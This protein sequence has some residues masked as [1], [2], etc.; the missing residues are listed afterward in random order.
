MHSFFADL[1]LAFYMIAGTDLQAPEI[2]KEMFD[3]CEKNLKRLFSKFKYNFDMNAD[4]D[5]EFP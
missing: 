1:D 3:F 4:P 5:P 2:K